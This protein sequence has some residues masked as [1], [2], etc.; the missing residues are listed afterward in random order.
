MRDFEAEKATLEADDAPEA[1]GKLRALH[2]AWARAVLEVEPTTPL[3]ETVRAALN[4]GTFVAQADA[5]AQ[6][7]NNAVRWQWV[8]DAT[9]KNELRTLQLARAWLLIVNPSTV[10]EARALATEVSRDTHVDEPV[11]ENARHLIT[12]LER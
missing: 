5:A 11:R 8:H 1:V 4:R 7:L 3:I 12:R 6:Q 10:A 9:N 2:E